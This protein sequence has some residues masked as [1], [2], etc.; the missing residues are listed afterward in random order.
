MTQ[1]TRPGEPTPGLAGLNAVRS[2]AGALHVY[3]ATAPGLT[4]TCPGRASAR[5]RS[6][7]ARPLSQPVPDTVVSTFGTLA[8]LIHLIVLSQQVSLPSPRRGFRVLAQRTDHR[9]TSPNESPAARREG[10]LTQGPGCDPGKYSHYVCQQPSSATAHEGVDL[11]VVQATFPHTRLSTTSDIYIHVLAE[12]QRRR[13]W[14]GHRARPPHE[15][16]QDDRREEQEGR[17]TRLTR[18]GL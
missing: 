14:H 11:K 3:P 9:M 2:R 13:R 12:V 8:K 6:W 5:Q 18:T 10:T 1:V 7:L 17:I 4:G 15:S 16:Q